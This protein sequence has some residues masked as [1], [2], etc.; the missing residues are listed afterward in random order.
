MSDQKRYILKLSACDREGLVARVSGFITEQ[1]GFI[2][3]AS[4]YSDPLTGDAFLRF[5]FTDA[6][7]NLPALSDI[8]TAFK[9]VAN[10]LEAEV[11]FCDISKP[12]PIV[13]AVSKF[14]HCL[15]D[16]VHRVQ[17]AILPVEIKAVI[18]NHE[19]M[20]SFVEWAGIPFHH[21][22]ITK[23]TKAQQE[24]QI[25]DILAET[26]SELLVLARYMQILSE[27][28]SAHV[29][30]KAINIHHSFL[31]SFK[32]ARPYSQAYERGVKVIGATAHY[33]TLDLDEGPIIEQAVERVDH[34]ASVD[35]F[36]NIGRDMECVALARAVRWHAERRLMLSGHRTIVFK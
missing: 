17:S 34:S 14:G 11:L 6:G 12:M 2:N 4:H 20:R 10:D 19:D 29:S 30:G 36:V 32:G 23:D 21:L 18:S 31:P 9:L 35:E 26:G 13:I 8:E 24:G 28:M 1:G 22:P 27:D 3:E 33:V 5:L 16:L 25:K 15:Y 7:G